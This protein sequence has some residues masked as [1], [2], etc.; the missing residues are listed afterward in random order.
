MGVEL[1]V[2]VQLQLVLGQDVLESLQVLVQLLPLEAEEAVLMQPVL[3]ILLVKQEAQAVEEDIK[4]EQV[5]QEILPRLLVHKE[6]LEAL[7]KALQFPLRLVAEEEVIAVLVQMV[8][9]VLEEMVEMEQSMELEEPLSL[10]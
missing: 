8:Q 5:E 2:Q 10:Q 9:V 7:A 6:M 3:L 1:E 4:V